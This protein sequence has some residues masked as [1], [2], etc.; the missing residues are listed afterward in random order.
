[1]GSSAPAR[2][3]EADRA[4]GSVHRLAVV[5]RSPGRGF[6]RQ[7]LDDADVELQRREHH[8]GKLS[9]ARDGQRETIQHKH[10]PGRAW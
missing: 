10:G 6:V 3:L 4:V 7:R 9:Q 1:M 5:R 2:G 8:R